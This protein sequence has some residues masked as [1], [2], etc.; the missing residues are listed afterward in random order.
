MRGLFLGSVVL[1]GA[2]LGAAGCA[3]DDGGSSGPPPQIVNLSLTDGGCEPSQLTVSEGRVQFHV[4]NP[5]SS[6]VTSMEIRSGR[7]VVGSVTNV[8]GGLTRFGTVDLDEGS[9]VLRCA[10]GSRGGEGTLIVER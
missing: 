3:G 9:Y 10:S 7:H 6:S 8:L 5:R 4:S 2:A 1:V